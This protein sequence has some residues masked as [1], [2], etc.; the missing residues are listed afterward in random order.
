MLDGIDAYLNKEISKALKES[1][2]E[3]ISDEEIEKKSKSEFSLEENFWLN[4]EYPLT[5]RT[6]T[7]NFT[8]GLLQNLYYVLMKQKGVIEFVKNEKNMDKL[9]DILA[10]FHRFSYRFVYKP[11]DNNQDVLKYI[12]EHLNFELHTKNLIVTMLSSIVTIEDEKLK[13]SCYL[14]FVRA[15][16]R[17]LAKIKHTDGM[18]RELHHEYS[19]TISRIGENVFTL[20][21]ISIVFI[22][23]KANFGEEE[24][25]DA[26]ETQKIFVEFVNGN[27][28]KLKT[29]MDEVF[30]DDKELKKSFESQNIFWQFLT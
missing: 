15:T 25:I 17:M 14:N 30:E 12:N 9:M 2:N 10:K 3:E 5:I 29:F 8:Y 11:K 26:S 18:Y 23:G 24:M 4:L 6:S 22:E 28:E 21:I 7:S 13:K 16:V 20:A 1:D 27:P 19:S